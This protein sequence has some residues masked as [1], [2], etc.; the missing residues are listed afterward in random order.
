MNFLLILY[1][2]TRSRPWLQLRCQA[3]RSDETADQGKKE[4]EKGQEVGL[5]SES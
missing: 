5:P 3:A 2:F 4:Q 1:T